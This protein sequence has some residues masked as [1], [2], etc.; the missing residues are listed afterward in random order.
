MREQQPRAATCMEV[1]ILPSAM[2]S[3][4]DM[5][6]SA[7]GTRRTGRTNLA[8]VWKRCLTRWEGEEREEGGSAA[9]F[10]DALIENEWRFG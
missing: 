9:A 5:R 1:V 10:E 3:M 4:R 6:G 8:M 2:V 7:S